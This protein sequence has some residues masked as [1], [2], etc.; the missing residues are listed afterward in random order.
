MP[1]HRTEPEGSFTVRIV[2]P[3]N[4]CTSNSNGPAGQAD[5]PEGIVAFMTSI[6]SVAGAVGELGDCSVAGIPPVKQGLG[7]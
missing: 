7:G 5:G 4:T 6:T 1:A 2:C 3:V